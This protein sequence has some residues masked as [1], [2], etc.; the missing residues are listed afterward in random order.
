[1][2][3]RVMKPKQDLQP[4]ISELVQSNENFRTKLSDQI[5]FAL[6]ST[7]RAVTNAYR[8]LLEEWGLT[9]PQYLVMLVLWEENTLNVGQIGDRLMLDSGTLTP[10]LKR[11]EIR[12]LIIRKREKS[13]ERQVNVS[14]TRSG[15]AMRLSAADIGR[16]LACK[17]AL[18]G[19][20]FVQLRNLLDSLKINLSHAEE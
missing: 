14:L 8:P 5:C 17:L 2:S 12:R 7:S 11:L 3:K 20:E 13:D 4:G 6:Y 18:S 9:Y 10:L 15:E 19:D 16:D 1:M